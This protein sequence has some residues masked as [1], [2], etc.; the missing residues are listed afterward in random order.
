[1]IF[2]RIIHHKTLAVPPCFY[3][4]GTPSLIRGAGERETGHPGEIP[5]SGIC[6][7]KNPQAGLYHVTIPSYCPIWVHLL[8][9]R[10]LAIKGL[11]EP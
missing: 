9:S 8:M 7:F 10:I 1:M 11:A 3:L 6:S 4:T 2:R 5:A